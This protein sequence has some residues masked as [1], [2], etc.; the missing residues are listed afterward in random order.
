MIRRSKPELM[1][2]PLGLW[3]HWQGPLSLLWVLP[4]KAADMIMS[5][6]LTEI[7]ECKRAFHMCVLCCLHRQT[8]MRRN[9]CVILLNMLMLQAEEKQQ[10]LSIPRTGFPWQLMLT[11]LHNSMTV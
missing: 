3:A 9:L 7:H 2:L 6:G 4:W 5:G 8:Y 1:P 10:I 11:C